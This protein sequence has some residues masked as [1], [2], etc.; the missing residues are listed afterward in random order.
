M[1][2]L[3]LQKISLVN[4]KIGKI[5]YNSVPR[6]KQSAEYVVEQHNT[7]V[8]LIEDSFVINI[9]WEFNKEKLMKN[10][11]EMKKRRY[12]FYPEKLI[13]TEGETFYFVMDRLR[14]LFVKFWESNEECTIVSHS[15]ITNIISLMFLQAP[16]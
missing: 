14:L 5:Y 3:E 12:M 1:P 13:I 9:S 11:L 8:E 10:I 4:E 15:A 6:D 2:I 7:P 16:L